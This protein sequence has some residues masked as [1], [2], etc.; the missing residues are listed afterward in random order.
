MLQNSGHAGGQGR[1][2]MFLTNLING[3]GSKYIPENYLHNV[4]ALQIYSIRMLALLQIPRFV[5]RPGECVVR[6]DEARHL[7]A[8]LAIAVPP[9]YLLRPR[10]LLVVGTDFPLTGTDSDRALLFG[11]MIFGQEDGC[12]RVG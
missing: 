6:P 10:A 12:Y 2:G 1:G 4:A 3:S 7:D 11:E 5:S 9:P 8:L